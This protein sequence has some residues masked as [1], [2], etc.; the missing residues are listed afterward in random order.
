MCMLSAS[1]MSNLSSSASYSHPCRRQHYQVPTVSQACS[2][3][4]ISTTSTV[5]TFYNTAGD[6]HIYNA[7]TSSSK[8]EFPTEVVIS[9]FTRYLTLE[10]Q[11]FY[12]LAAT[13]ALHDSK[14]R[15]PQPKCHPS[16]RT[17]ILQRIFNWAESDSAKRIL[18]LSGSPGAGKSAIA[19]TIA[20]RCKQNIAECC[21]QKV[22]L[23]AAL[24]FFRSSSERSTSVRL[25]A[26]L[27][28]EITLF[29][30]GAKEFITK[31]IMDDP[32]IFKK[33]INSQLL[34]LTIRPLALAA[35]EWNSMQQLLIIIDGLDEC[36]DE[37]EQS[38]ILSAISNALA[39]SDLPIR[40]FITSRPES[41]IRTRFERTDLQSATVHFV[42]DIDETA[43][44]DIATYLTT[45][46]SR[47]RQEHCIRET[48]WSPEDA[49]Q[50]LAER[51][52]GQFVYASTII[53]FLDE[54]HS[55]PQERLVVVMGT[56][57]RGTFW[58]FAEIDFL[59]TQILDA[60]PVSEVE[61]IL[62]CLGAIIF[63][64]ALTPTKTLRVWCILTSCSSSNLGEL[65]TFSWIYTRY[66][67]F[68][69]KFPFAIRRSQIF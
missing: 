38:D 66:W 46:V 28:Y 3:I 69:Q 20:E 21:E 40:F 9:I 63:L 45:G 35:R 30:P 59:Y 44:Q 34:H 53:K 26:T 32:A 14:E 5:E 52:S 54:R 25:V 17:R 24:F 43:T 65:G 13:S 4:H 49:V 8:R 12:G 6:A 18:W 47:I 58:P 68:N 10:L 29:V 23:A 62:L 22:R 31:A 50:S 1:L 55:Q 48:T 11:D 19:Q 67:M 37:I 51:A 2:M 7:T 41:H 27:A 42:L 60:V 33:D 57:L 56:L 16:T 36:T 39:T 61:T 15:F 64:A